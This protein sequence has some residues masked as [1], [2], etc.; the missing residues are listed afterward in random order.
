M[1]RV[2]LSDEQ[3]AVFDELCTFLYESPDRY[4][5]MHGLAGTGKTTVLAR[6]AEEFPH[7]RLCTMTGKAASV[8]RN[9]TGLDAA[10]IHSVFYKLLDEE[11]DKKGRKKLIFEN[12]L[13]DGEMGGSIVLLDECSM[14]NER[15]ARDIF[16]TG[17][18]IIAC[19]D[20][21]QL[22]PVEG[23]QFFRSPHHTLQTIH[24][25]AL[26][27]P[28][29][30]QAHRVRSGERYESDGDTFRVMAPRSL[31]NEEKLE[32]D[33]VLCW[34]NKTRHAINQHLRS[35]HGYSIMP[36]PQIGEPVMC[37]KNARDF[38]IFNGAVYTLAE[39]FMEGDTDISL[40]VDGELIVVPNVTF[41][42]L[43]SALPSGVDPVTYFDFGYA[44]TVHKAQGSEWN[45]VILIDEYRRQEQRKEWL[46]TAITRAANKI[47][48]IR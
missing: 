24:R 41:H 14:I 46:Y 11:Y 47:T 21:G 27:N 1:R 48:I 26:E 8:L 15:I 37:M 5:V 29:I 35:L 7:A 6:I 3:S 32:A 45:N 9:K 33:V 25:Q 22:P 2:T 10:T 28:I 40:Y 13:E 34:T 39:P 31:S 16:A 42:G 30:R 4:R 12:A 19:G 20:P 17:A 36:H 18:K 38:G 44:M 23:E 43:K